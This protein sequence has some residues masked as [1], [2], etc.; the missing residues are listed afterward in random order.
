MTTNISYYTKRCIIRN[1][2]CHYTRRYI[3]RNKCFLIHESVL[4]L[5]EKIYNGNDHCHYIRSI[6]DNIYLLLYKKMCNNNKHF[7]IHENKYCH[8]T[9]RC[10]MTIFIFII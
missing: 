2:C 6:N 8:Y 10:I 5:H 1:V 9:R 3:I 4:S 7:L